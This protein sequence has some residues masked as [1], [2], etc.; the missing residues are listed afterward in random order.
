MD[1]FQAICSTA[2]P[3]DGVTFD[4]ERLTAAPIREDLECGGVR[5]QTYAVIDGARIPI[6]VD[7][8]RSNH[9]LRNSLLLLRDRP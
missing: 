9:D 6:Q 7:I 5:V 1:T 8:H 2:V 3:N 4:V